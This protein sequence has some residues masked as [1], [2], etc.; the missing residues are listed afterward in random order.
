MSLTRLGAEC[1]MVALGAIDA[2]FSL[3]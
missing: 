2:W 3:V 1:K